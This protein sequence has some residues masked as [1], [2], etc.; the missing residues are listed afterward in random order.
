MDVPAHMPSSVG[1]SIP[2][3]VHRC[4][5]LNEAHE[6]RRGT[7]AR[8]DTGAVIDALPIPSYEDRTGL[9]YALGHDGLDA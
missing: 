5:V 2:S 9:M 1:Q 6:S 4:R 8:R 3:R 7:D